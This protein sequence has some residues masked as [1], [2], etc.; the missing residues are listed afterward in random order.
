[1]ATSLQDIITRL[2]AEIAAAKATR[3]RVG[4]F[5]SLYRRVTLEI[6][7]RIEQGLF[8]NSAAMVDLDLDFATRYFDALDAFRG[9]AELSECWRTAFEG[10]ADNQLL[11][12]QHLLLGMNAHINFDLAISTAKVA[13]NGGGLAAMQNDFNDVNSIFGRLTE[14]VESRIGEVSPRFHELD[15][16]GG[17][18]D[19][20]ALGFSIRRARQ[21]AWQTAQTI[22][23]LG[24]AAQF[25]T[26]VHDGLVAG[27]GEAIISP[28]TTVALKHIRESESD[29][30]AHIIDVFERS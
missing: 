23:R 27:F 28:L 7:R 24:A 19:E 25:L 10:S 15:T 1:M 21:Q 3:S 26:P 4:F 18:S 9:G 8:E 5:A 13:R 17:N 12:V 2:E 14:D 11:I 16:L 29:D 6:K 22:V 20:I 30:V